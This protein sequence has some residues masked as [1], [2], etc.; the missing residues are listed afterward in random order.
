MTPGSVV[1]VGHNDAHVRPGSKGVVLGW[2]EE[3]GNPLVLV[4]GRRV[5]L[6]ASQ[7]RSETAPEPR[8]AVR[9][10]RAQRYGCLVNGCDRPHSAKGYC[11]VHYNRWRKYGD[12][13]MVTPPGK[14]SAEAVREEPTR[15]KAADGAEDAPMAA[16]ATTDV[17]AR[18]EAPERATDGTAAIE[19]RRVRAACAV[20]GCDGEATTRG[21]CHAHYQRWRKHGDPLVVLAPGQ[22]LAEVRAMP[23]A[24]E[25]IRETARGNGRKRE[26][27]IVEAATTLRRRIAAAATSGQPAAEL[28][29]LANAVGLLEAGTE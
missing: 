4:E 21:W 7:I 25:A 12:P 23:E 3:T 15:N 29:R 28:V 10:R 22:R 5:A 24:A 1:V 16:G 9:K 18:P 6:L 19:R 14:T 2:V 20:E 17:P 11:G 13:L 26:D 8:P 27:P